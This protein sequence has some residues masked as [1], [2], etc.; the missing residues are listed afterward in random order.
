MRSELYHS[1]RIYLITSRFFSPDIQPSILTPFCPCKADKGT[2]YPSHTELGRKLWP[3]RGFAI[4]SVRFCIWL[5]FCPCGYFPVCFLCALSPASICTEYTD[6]IF[7]LFPPRRS[8]RRANCSRVRASPLTA[9]GTPSCSMAA[10]ICSFPKESSG[11]L[12]RPF[13]RV[14]LL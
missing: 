7:Y 13:K 9:A 8:D 5:N 11:E 12:F 14:F 2:I 3:K 4:F 10:A 6:A 1:F